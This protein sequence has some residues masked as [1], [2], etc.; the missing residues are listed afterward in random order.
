MFGKVNRVQSHAH[1]QFCNA[2]C[3][4]YEDTNSDS[5]V[6]DDTNSDSDSDDGS[7]VTEED[8]GKADFKKNYKN[9]DLK[10]SFVRREKVRVVHSLVVCRDWL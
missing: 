3:L 4:Q 5:F 7:I 9:K 10:S 1:L 6:G 8:E 2:V